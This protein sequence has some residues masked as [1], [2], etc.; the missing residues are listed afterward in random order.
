MTTYMFCECAP[1]RHVVEGLGLVFS[2]RLKV[3]YERH[4]QF[5]KTQPGR[6]TIF[7]GIGSERR[8]PAVSSR[9]WQG[10][11][12]RDLCCALCGGAVLEK[13][14][15]AAPMKATLFTSVEEKA[16]PLSATQGGVVPFY[17]EPRELMAKLF[18]PPPADAHPHGA[19]CTCHYCQVQAGKNQNGDMLP[20][21][22]PASTSRQRMAAA[23][24]QW[25]LD[26]TAWETRLSMFCEVGAGTQALL[27]AR[28]TLAGLKPGSLST[29][30]S[31]SSFVV[32][33]SDG[34]YTYIG[35]G[36]DAFTQ[37]A[38]SAEEHSR[39]KETR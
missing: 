23:A 3:E 33:I 24:A 35:T 7:R 13:D 28:F 38:K 32:N 17:A 16:V 19:G 21:P 31:G 4:E 18:S 29:L 9:V 12:I 26:V 6:L 25:D 22:S 34:A 5:L 15:V 37:V 8:F 20:P 30:G 2:A 11:Q 1:A 39:R 27:A 10:R 14:V 36:Y